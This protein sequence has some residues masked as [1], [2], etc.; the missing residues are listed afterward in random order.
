MESIKQFKKSLTRFL[1][2]K[3]SH[4]EDQVV[5]GWY[6][7]YEALEKYAFNDTDKARIREELQMAIL[8]H[9]VKPKVH[10]LWWAASAAVVILAGS[11]ALWSVRHR[12]VN[13]PVAYLTSATETGMLKYLML[14]DS[15]EVWLNAASKFKYPQAFTANSRTVYL[16]EGE[17]FFH[18]KRD[19]KRPF[20][21]NM[22][23]LQVTVLGT[24]FDI[25]NYGDLTTQTI[26]VNTGKV[27]VA[28][29]KRVL[30]VLEKGDQLVYH[31]TSQA[32]ELSEVDQTLS[33]SWRDGKTVLRNASFQSVASV[34][35]N[36]YGVT[37]H[38]EISNIHRF[39][40]TAT[41]QSQVTLQDNLELICKMHHIQYRKE[42]NVVVL[43]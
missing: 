43:Y 23:A 2:R 39:S 27:R 20:N 26:V 36:L 17:A 24:S 25:N 13:T 38:S 1:K 19:V 22:G 4:K 18:V 35:K 11:F 7:S 34:F 3:S 8:P 40:Y 32:F 14:P 28:S 6:Q 16:P 15:T 31:K 41:I 10:R 21:V 30:A 42:G 12:T 37:L 9:L 29:G 5:E 33:Y